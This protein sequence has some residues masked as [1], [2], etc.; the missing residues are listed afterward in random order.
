M[1]MTPIGSNPKKHDELTKHK[2][3]ELFATFWV[4]PK[5]WKIPWDFV[6]VKML[7]VLAQPVHKC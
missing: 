4:L 3:V 5:H 6:K 2:L 7:R 1:V